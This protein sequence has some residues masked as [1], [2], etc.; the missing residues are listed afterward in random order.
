MNLGLSAALS[1][2]V[3]V[4]RSHDHGQC[5]SIAPWRS[6]ILFL[7]C[8]VVHATLGGL[9][10]GGPAAFA[11]P[12]PEI[13]FVFSQYSVIEGYTDAQVALVISEPPLQAI[14]AYVY[15][16]AGTATAGEDFVGGSTFAS[17]Q[18]AGPDTKYLRRQDPVGFRNLLIFK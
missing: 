15:I 6:T 7:L 18:P 11:Q 9:I 2:L 10:A 1:V 4:P 14:S 5:P 13:R 16:D 3:A 12:P 8:L 17:F